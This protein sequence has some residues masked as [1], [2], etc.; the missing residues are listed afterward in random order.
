[1]R[2]KIYQYEVKFICGMKK[3]GDVVAAGRYFTAINVNNPNKENVTIRKR[4]S[5]AYPGEKVGPITKF[6]KVEF[7]E[8]QSFEIDCP[9]IKRHLKDI[10]DDNEKFVKGFVIIQS[11]APLHVTAVYTVEDLKGNIRSMDVERELP[12]KIKIDGKI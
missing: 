9:D 8:H 6:F 11:P 5:V 2:K 3:K 10:I 12:R 7:K 4:I 1:M